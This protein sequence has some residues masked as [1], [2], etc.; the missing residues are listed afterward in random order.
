MNELRHQAPPHCK[1]LS[2]LLHCLSIMSWA[3][4]GATSWLLISICLEEVLSTG[5]LALF[6]QRGSAEHTCCLRAPTAPHPPQL[7]PSSFSLLATGAYGVLTA[8]LEVKQTAVAERKDSVTFQTSSDWKNEKRLPIIF[9]YLHHNSYQLNSEFNISANSIYHL[10]LVGELLLSRY[11]SLLIHSTEQSLVRLFKTRTRLGQLSQ[12]LFY[13]VQINFSNV[14]LWSL[15]H[16]QGVT[17]AALEQ[18]VVQ[19]S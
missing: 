7:G 1:L 10:H 8:S 18:L 9:I 11:N 4:A 17:L 6:N 15:T 16:S 14:W 12:W 3:L 19:L 2:L 5:L 13:R